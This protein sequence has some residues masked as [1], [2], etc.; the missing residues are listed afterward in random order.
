ML[1]NLARS[2]LAF[3]A[4]LGCTTSADA[5]V[6]C[7]VNKQTKIAVEGTSFVAPRPDA[8]PA[9][10]VWYVEIADVA[11]GYVELKIAVAGGGPAGRTDYTTLLLGASHVV[12]MTGLVANPKTNKGEDCALNPGN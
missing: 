11:T 4:A 7:A 10:W 6:Y 9:L 8:N 12:E 2:A 1:G 5:S 3:G